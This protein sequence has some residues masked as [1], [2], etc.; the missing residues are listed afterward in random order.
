MLEKT[1]ESVPNGS[2]KDNLTSD[3]IVLSK[4]GIVY[5]NKGTFVQSHELLSL[6]E[7]T[8]S[9][10]NQA[11]ISQEIQVLHSSQ[12]AKKSPANIQSHRSNLFGT[13]VVEMDEDVEYYDEE[14]EYYD[15]ESDKSNA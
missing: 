6:Q 8:V 14:Q 13:D 15:E 5:L 9:D 2:K 7:S 1:S 3:E 11:M 10:Q 12:S 4:N